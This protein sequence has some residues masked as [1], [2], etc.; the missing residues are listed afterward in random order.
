[1][2]V[3]VTGVGRTSVDQQTGQI[4]RGGWCHRPQAPQRASSRR[5]CET[6]PEV[7]SGVAVD[8]VSR[9]S[10][11]AGSRRRPGLRRRWRSGWRAARRRTIL[12][13]TERGEAAARRRDPRG[14]CRGNR[15]RDDARRSGPTPGTR[16]SW[17]P[18]TCGTRSSLQAQAERMPRT[19]RI[20][21]DEEIVHVD[22]RSF[23][24]ALPRIMTRKGA[25]GLTIA[26]A[27][28]PTARVARRARPAARPRPG[29]HLGRGHLLVDRVVV[30]PDR[31]SRARARRC[32]RRERVA[33]V[34][35]PGCRTRPAGVRRADADARR[36]RRGRGAAARGR[37]SG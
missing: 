2:P 14:E 7:G 19:E 5:W 9:G 3:P 17:S 13:R 36:R 24:R 37:T 35:D 26:E 1:M 27:S 25:D 30:E 31:G 4:G 8:R 32:A 15:D 10:A 11:R 20:S 29:G 16:T 22:G 23:T 21:D 18:R 12:C 6:G 34:R 28:H 33:R